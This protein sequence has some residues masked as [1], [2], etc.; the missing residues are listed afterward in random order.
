MGRQ[1]EVDDIISDD[2]YPDP[3]LVHFNIDDLRPV[4]TQAA[5]DKVKLMRELAMFY[6]SHY[7]ACQMKI[8]HCTDCI[9]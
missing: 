7:T 3:S 8:I 2:D 9:L 1:I 6:K 5:W 4:F